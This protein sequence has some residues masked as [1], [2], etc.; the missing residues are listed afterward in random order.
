MALVEKYV[1]HSAQAVMFKRSFVF[2]AHRKREE[3]DAEGQ[4]DYTLKISL[5]DDF[6]EE[7][8]NIYLDSE[9]ARDLASQLSILSNWIRNTIDNMKVV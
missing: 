8:P 5:A 3:R 6:E 7:K 4:D 1:E 9:D 2:T